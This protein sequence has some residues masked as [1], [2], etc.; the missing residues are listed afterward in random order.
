MTA[1][2]VLLLAHHTNTHS[3]VVG[4]V[5]WNKTRHGKNSDFYYPGA[6]ARDPIYPTRPSSWNKI[7]FLLCFVLL[8]C[9]LPIANAASSWLRHI[10]RTLAQLTTQS[11]NKHE[12]SHTHTAAKFNGNC[13]ITTRNCCLSQETPKNAFTKNALFTVETSPPRPKNTH[14]AIATN[15]RS[16]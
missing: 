8:F 1:T 5:M 2:F 4:N 7:S 10:K 16:L 6:T 12:H 13:F 14:K 9:F 3:I 11:P 15:F